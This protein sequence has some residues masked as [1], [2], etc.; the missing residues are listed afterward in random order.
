MCLDFKGL[1]IN[2]FL[3]HMLDSS[4]SERN[5]Y[6]KTVEDVLLAKKANSNIV[7]FLWH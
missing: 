3:P 5:A 6:I 4:V 1:C 7:H 2:I